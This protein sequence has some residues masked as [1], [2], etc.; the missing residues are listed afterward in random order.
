MAQNNQPN[1][2]MKPC[3]VCGG[4]CTVFPHKP[5]ECPTCGELIYWNDP[6]YNENNNLTYRTDDRRDI[7][8]E[9]W[10]HGAI[11]PPYV[12]SAVKKKIPDPPN[13][14]AVVA[15]LCIIGVL[16]PPIG[17]LMSM[18]YGFRRYKYYPNMKTTWVFVIGLPSISFFITS[19]I[20]LAIIWF[21]GKAILYALSVN[22]PF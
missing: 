21:F 7:E 8:D 14:G 1:F 9:H 18:I 2:I 22:P 16:L 13:S 5:T 11:L 15:L 20:W 3:R 6:V 10:Y 19:P 12:P 17:S 4:M